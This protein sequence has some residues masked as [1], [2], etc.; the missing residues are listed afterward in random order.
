MNTQCKNYERFLSETKRDSV[1]I[2]LEMTSYVRSLG[3]VIKNYSNLS[4][5]KA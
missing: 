3:F 4:Y 5:T 1:M 2:P